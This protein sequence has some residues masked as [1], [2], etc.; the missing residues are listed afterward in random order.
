MAKIFEQ[1][2]GVNVIAEGSNL[3]GNIVTSGDCRIDGTMK[4]NIQSNA[5]VIVGATG[6]IEGEIVCKNIE[7]EGK[8]KA[9]INVGEL[10]CI[11]SNATLI[12]NVIAGKLSIEPGANFIGNCKMQNMKTEIPVVEKPEEPK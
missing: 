4:G 7:I 10:L 1:E 9:N 11:R 8:I 2:V 6:S 12:G 5:K 3:T